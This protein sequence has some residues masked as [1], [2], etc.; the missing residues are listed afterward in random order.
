MVNELGYRSNH[1]ARSLRQKQTHTIGVLVHE[2]NSNFITSV[3][4]GIEKVATE[5]GYDLIIAHSGEN[6]KKE[7]ANARN[8]F[9]QAGRRAHC[10]PF[11]RY[12]RPRSLQAVCR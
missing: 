12:H 8:L 3:L 5:A 11:I 9:S 2:L 4:A 10:V 6:M 7:E 1:F